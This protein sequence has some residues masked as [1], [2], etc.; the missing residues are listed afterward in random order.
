MGAEYAH[1]LIPLDRSFVPT[2]D[3]LALLISTM[4]DQNYLPARDEKNQKGKL[5]YIH[6]RAHDGKQWRDGTW[7]YPAKEPARLLMPYPITTA[8]FSK[9]EEN[10]LAVSWLVWDWKEPGLKHT[11]AP[12]YS[13]KENVELARFEMDLF[14]GRDYF[15]LAVNEFIQAANSQCCCGAELTYSG[16]SCVPRARVRRHCSACGLSYDASSFKAWACLENILSTDQS[17]RTEFC[18]GGLSRFAIRLNVGKVLP[19][20]PPRFDPSFV[21]LCETVLGQQMIECGEMA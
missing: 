13:K 8:W 15:D 4:I 21:Q 2:S 12:S 7:E 19:D 10:D 16:V 18:G 1:S 14:V 17:P 20:L 9:F 11:L 3:Q 6:S 5:W